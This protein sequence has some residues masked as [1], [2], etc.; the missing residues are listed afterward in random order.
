M[1]KIVVDTGILK[2]GQDASK[3]KGNSFRTIEIC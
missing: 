3:T 1:K 2:G